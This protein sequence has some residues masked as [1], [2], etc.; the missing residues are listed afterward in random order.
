MSPRR[1]TMTKKLA[2]ATE[3]RQR[4]VEATLKLHGEY[5]IFGTSWKD[6]ATEANVSVGTVYRYFPTRDQLVPKG[7]IAGWE[8]VTGRSAGGGAHEDH[9]ALVGLLA[10]R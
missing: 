4:I 9:K 7:R 5:G 2:L 6:I 3:T 10:R 8:G 1:Y